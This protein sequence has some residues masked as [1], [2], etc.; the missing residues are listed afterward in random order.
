M[1]ASKDIDS[2]LRRSLG[3]RSSLVLV[4]TP[5]RPYFL[6]RTSG[7]SQNSSRLEMV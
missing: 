4:P 1:G 7:Q 2:W 6:G 3:R 5:I